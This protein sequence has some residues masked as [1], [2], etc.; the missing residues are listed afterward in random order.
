MILLISLRVIKFYEIIV[1]LQQI[2]GPGIDESNLIDLLIYFATSPTDPYK[3]AGYI[4]FLAEAMS[5]L[6]TYHRKR[7]SSLENL[8]VQSIPVTLVVLSSLSPN[9]I[10][11][12]PC[13]EVSQKKE[14]EIVCFT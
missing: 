4:H 8:M 3:V 13:A 6:D 1:S 14:E 10:T 7:T 12:C 9:A 5:Q 11:F 2:S